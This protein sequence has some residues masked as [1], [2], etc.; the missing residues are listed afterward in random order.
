MLNESQE[1]LESNVEKIVM[2]SVR[3]L[4]AQGGEWALSDAEWKRIAE[5]LSGRL[6]ARA[7]GKKSSTRVFIDAVLWVAGADAYWHCLP[8]EFGQKNHSVYV[9]FSRWA[10]AGRWD[11]ILNQLPADDERRIC[12]GKLV[13]AHLASLERKK[14]YSA[15]RTPVVC[16]EVVQAASPA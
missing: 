8:K 11:A 10:R 4:P 13:G 3:S 2:D 16:L 1:M 14:I 9:R 6:G 5:S 12:L 15:T 7:R